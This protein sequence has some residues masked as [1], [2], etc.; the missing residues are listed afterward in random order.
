MTHNVWVRRKEGAIISLITR[1]RKSVSET[2][3]QDGYG[4][5]LKSSLFQLGRVTDFSTFG[6]N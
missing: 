6:Q 5:Q 2:V 4:S 3:E 1:G